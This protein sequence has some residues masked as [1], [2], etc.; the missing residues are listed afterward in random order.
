MGMNVA[1]SD[2]PAAQAGWITRCR[3]GDEQAWRELY[4]RYLPL[5]HRVALRMGASDREVA[6]VCQEVFLRVH[7]GL[8]SFRG[9]AQLSTWFYR[10]TA[11]EVSRLR[12]DA[13]IR[14]TLAS[15]LGREPEPPPIADRT[16]ASRRA[17][18]CASSKACSRG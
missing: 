11:N 17:K 5:V 4:D 8:A 15:L 13:G 10:I 9:D 2:G 12:R 18:R 1:H 6:D 14:R 3:A 16:E 7:R